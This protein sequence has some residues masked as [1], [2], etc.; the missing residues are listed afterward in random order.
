MTEV[1]PV[2]DQSI[3]NENT[4]KRPPDKSKT[5][6]VKAIAPYQKPVLWRSLWQIANSLGPYM[7]LWFVAYKLLAVSYLA[8]LGVCVLSGGFLI[9]VFIIAHDCGHGSFFKSRKANAI[10]GSIASTLP[11]LPYHAWRHEHAVHH[12]HSGDL[13]HRGMGDIETLTVDEYLKLGRWE[14]VQYRVYRNPWVMFTIGPIYIFMINYRYWRKDAPRRVKLSILRTNIALAAITIIGGLVFGFKAYL[15][16]QLPVIYFSGAMGIWMFYMQHQFDGVYWE[17]H[18]DWGFFDQAVKGSSYYALPK[19]LQWFSGNI[20]F[21]HVHHLG[22]KVPNYFLE[23]CHREL[24]LFR[25]V[26]PVTLKKSLKCL[27][28]RL[29][30][31]RGK[32]LVGFAFAHNAE[33][34]AAGAS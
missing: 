29:Y 20:G 14:R 23:K 30:D 6:W 19:V 22:A 21:H 10:C 18:E 15:M 3:P 31:E 33:R 13:D 27:S 12:A 28:F 8:S 7:I 25:D 34:Q 32:Q 16:I 2:A 24:E 5:S 11:Q 26:N 4:S 1:P 9:R 17:R